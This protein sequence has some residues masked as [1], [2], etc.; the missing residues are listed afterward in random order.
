MTSHPEDLLSAYVDDEISEEERQVIEAHL[1]SCE[2]CQSFVDELYSFKLQ[3]QTILTLEQPSVQFETRV[4]QAIRQQST[5]FRTTWLTLPLIAMMLLSAVGITMALMYG[6]FIHG[7]IRL[8][9]AI[10]YA[11]THMVSEIP[12]VSIS[13]I[14]VSLFVLVASIYSLRR[15]LQLTPVERG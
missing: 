5:D 4:M 8:F 7:F 10:V 9:V 3:M 15:V 11:I 6:K 12:F 2:S 13:V 14:V 1:V